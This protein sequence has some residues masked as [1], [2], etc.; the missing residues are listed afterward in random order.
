ML[1]DLQSDKS[2]AFTNGCM[3]YLTRPDKFYTKAN[4]NTSTYLE[5]SQLFTTD[6]SGF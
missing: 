3:T 1:I 5:I 2:F 6:S 4:S